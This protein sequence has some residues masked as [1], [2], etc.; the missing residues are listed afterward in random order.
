M[1]VKIQFLVLLMQSSDHHLQGMIYY[2]A[3]VFQNR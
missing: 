2:Y 1:G 3:D